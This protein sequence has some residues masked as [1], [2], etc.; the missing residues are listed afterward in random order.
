MSDDL[1]DAL[2]VVTAVGSG[3]NAGV[4]FAFSVFVMKALA[5]LPPATGAAAMQSIN[6]EAPTPWFM[7]ALFGT[8]L[9]SVALAA[10]S[11][12]RLD[13][14]EGVTRLIASAL[15]LVA[16]VLTGTYHV[17]RNNALANLDPDDPA[18]AAHWRTYAREWTSLNHVRTLGPLAAATA[19]TISLATN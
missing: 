14:P 8:A 15:Y 18:T 2:T 13:E 19:L 9:F 17:P 3:L 7:S 12:F 11:L 6:V 1:Y 4:F 10:A 5:E 16:I